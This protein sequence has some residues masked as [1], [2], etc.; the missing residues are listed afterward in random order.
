MKKIVAALII[1][2]PIVVWSGEQKVVELSI[3]GMA[4][5]VCAY[6]VEKNLSELPGVESC[7]VNVKEGTARIVLAP[8][9]ALNIEEM[10]EVVMSFGF[11]PGEATVQPGA[12]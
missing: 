5:P 9:A 4:C 10:K 3:K 8:G 2:F 11:T 12:N 7:D 6:G 1:L